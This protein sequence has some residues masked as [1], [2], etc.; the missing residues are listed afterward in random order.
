MQCLNQ[1]IKGQLR[2]L[3]QVC[4]E[5]AAEGQYEAEV[6]TLYSL[7]TDLQEE[8]DSMQNLVQ[9]TYQSYR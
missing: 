3:R 5:S 7:L 1:C 9:E 8:R 6:A 4:L 2:D